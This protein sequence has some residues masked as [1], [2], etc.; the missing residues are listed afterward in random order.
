[1]DRSSVMLELRL[2]QTS[3]VIKE[4]P[5]MEASSN[6]LTHTF[7]GHS[8]ANYHKK[9]SI[10]AVGKTKFRDSNPNGNSNVINM[11]V[12]GVF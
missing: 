7:A 9:L 12:G 3:F 4:K 1:M 10:I 6:R 11:A 8:V 5:R 2:R